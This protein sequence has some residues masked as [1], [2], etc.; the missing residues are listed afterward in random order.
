MTLLSRLIRRDEGENSMMQ[1]IALSVSAILL[2]AGLVTFPGVIKPAQESVA[3]SVVASVV[4]IQAEQL[5]KHG[6]YS[7]ISKTFIQ[8]GSLKGG[9]DFD[10]RFA[11][12]NAAVSHCTNVAVIPGFTS[13][14]ISEA[15]QLQYNCFTVFVRTKTVVYYYQT[16]KIGAGEQVFKLATPT[17]ETLPSSPAAVQYKTGKAV[18]EFPS[19]YAQCH[20]NSYGLPTNWWPKTMS[21]IPW[22]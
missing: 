22:Y 13:P 14:D 21:E 3:R 9:T 12:C 5:A 7:P 8:G 4:A 11:G 10:E 15:E 1:V 2:T 16:K 20:S 19:A 18:T 17:K 6:S